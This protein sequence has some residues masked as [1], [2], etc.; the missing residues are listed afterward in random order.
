MPVSKASERIEQL[1]QEINQHNYRYYVL[2]APVV[3]D[4]EYDALLPGGS[5]EA[6]LA[7]AVLVERDAAIGR[8]EDEKDRRNTSAIL[9]AAIYGAS[10]L[11]ALLGGPAS[12]AEEDH[13]AELGML[14]PPPG[15]EAALGVRWN[16]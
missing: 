15:G 3:S 5:A 1:R 7:R 9:A 11:D 4:V 14:A 12:P 6:A 13:G 2:N 16:F 8:S 10:I